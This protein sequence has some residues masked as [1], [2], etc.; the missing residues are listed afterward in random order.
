M[1]LVDD[2][3]EVGNYLFFIYHSYYKEK[4]INNAT[5][6]FICA[7]NYLYFSYSLSNLLAASLFFAGNSRACDTKLDLVTKKEKPPKTSL[8]Y[9]TNTTMLPCFCL[10]PCLYLFSHPLKPL[11]LIFSPRL[12][13]YTSISKCVTM[14]K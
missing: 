6:T 8:F 10:S 4:L 3:S 11:S 14:F 13:K 1:K 5:R 2:I 9:T 12:S 7:I